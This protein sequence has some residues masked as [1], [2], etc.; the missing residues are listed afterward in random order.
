MYV[1]VKINQIVNSNGRAREFFGASLCFSVQKLMTYNDIF[2]K[3]IRSANC[4]RLVP[5]KIIFMIL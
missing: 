5:P 4:F 2:D 1:M 3:D